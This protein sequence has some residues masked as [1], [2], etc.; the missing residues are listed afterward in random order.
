MCRMK[1]LL[2]S[3][4]AILA[5]ALCISSC[6]KDSKAEASVSYFIECD[7]IQYS[8]TLNAKYDQF[9]KDALGA[10]GM[11]IT[12]LG[13]FFTESSSVTQ[14]NIPLAQ[15]NCNEQAKV[16]YRKKLGTIN[17]ESLTDAIF[18]V[19]YK[20]LAEEG[21]TTASALNLGTMRIYT[22]LWIIPMAHEFTLFDKN[23]NVIE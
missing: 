10:D 20:E 5:G 7:S 8:D 13:C 9:I 22:S 3:A 19:H 15:F 16:T 12:S 23:L 18:K 2:I 14:N 6:S 17:K 11:R 21:I 4:I 1:N